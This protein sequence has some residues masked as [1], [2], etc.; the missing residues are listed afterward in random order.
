MTVGSYVACCAANVD[1]SAIYVKSP[2]CPDS[3]ANQ[4]EQAFSI[5]VVNLHC[6][7]YRRT[8]HSDTESVQDLA[9]PDSRS[10]WS[11]RSRALL[12]Y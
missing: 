12:W 7:S 3:L 1:I 6:P 10:W 4:K 8:D 11:V 2:S 9:R 5:D